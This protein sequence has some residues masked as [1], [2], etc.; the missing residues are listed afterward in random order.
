MING[1]LNRPNLMLIK[2]RIETIKVCMKTTE[3]LRDPVS[4]EVERNIAPI[5]FLGYK[6]A[7]VL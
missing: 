5:K 4:F 7:K 3:Q 2:C 1:L 6:F